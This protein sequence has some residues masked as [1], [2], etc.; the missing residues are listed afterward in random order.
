MTI[1]ISTQYQSPA[2]YHETH[3]VSLPEKNFLHHLIKPTSSVLELG[4]G[5][6]RLY[7][8]LG[9]GGRKY[10]GLDRER[11][12]LDFFLEK[13]PDA[14]VAEADWNDWPFLVENFDFVMMARNT[15]FHVYPDFRLSLLGRIFSALGDKG[16]FVLE[17]DSVKDC[18]KAQYVDFFPHSIAEIVSVLGKAGFLM[19]SRKSLMGVKT[20]LCFRK[21]C[22]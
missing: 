19:H 17:V 10:F 20:A 2:V 12:M 4:C 6:G 3:L 16:Q 7:P 15:W 13:C 21:A 5:T 1:L 18:D 14:C 8:I 9:T 11:L 22:R